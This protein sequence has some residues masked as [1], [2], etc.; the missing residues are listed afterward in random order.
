MMNRIKET[1]KMNLTRI[2]LFSVVISFGFTLVLSTNAKYLSYLNSH[3]HAQ[4]GEFYF[5]STYLTDDHVTYTVNT[6]N[7]TEYKVLLQFMN[8]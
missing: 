4:A 7:R 8:L 6:W 2:L 1:L 3:T 5:E